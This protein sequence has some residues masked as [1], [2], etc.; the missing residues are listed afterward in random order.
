MRARMSVISKK[1][2]DD[3]KF[4]VRFLTGQIGCPSLYQN[5]VHDQGRTACPSLT[6]G[7]QLGKNWGSIKRPARGEVR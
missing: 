2:Q 7:K 3:T 5:T 4:G 1:N 6:W